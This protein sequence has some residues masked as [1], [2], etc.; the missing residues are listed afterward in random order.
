MGGGG[1]SGN[2]LRRVNKSVSSH[3]LDPIVAQVLESDKATLLE[4]R[5]RYSLED[6]YNLWEVTYTA[7]YNQWQ[8]EDRARRE[9]EMRN[10]R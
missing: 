10:G 1:G 5:E 4:L 3:N 6:L 8:R 7:K 9:F 2:G